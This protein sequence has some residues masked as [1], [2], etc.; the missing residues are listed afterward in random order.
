MKKVLYRKFCIEFEVL[1]FVLSSGAYNFLK[2]FLKVIIRLFVST[3]NF[4]YVF[5]LIRFFFIY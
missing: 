2:C 5:L 3:R 4:Y 1:Y